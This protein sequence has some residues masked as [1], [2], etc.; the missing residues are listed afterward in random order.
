M[1]LTTELSDLARWRQSNPDLASLG[2]VELAQMI[3]SEYPGTFKELPKSSLLSRTAGRVENVFGGLG[4]NIG[5]LLGDRPG[6]NPFLR[7]PGRAASMV[8]QSIP[9][10]AIQLAGGRLAG[11][12]KSA[13]PLLGASGLAGFSQ[14]QRTKAAGGGPAEAAGAGLG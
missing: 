7:V 14:Y 5:S 8:V 2:D 11:R 10:L 3:E 12:L 9:E 6:V 1:P 13:A 4:E